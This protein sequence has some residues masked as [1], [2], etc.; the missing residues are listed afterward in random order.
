MSSQVLA[1]KFLIRRPEGKLVFKC[2]YKDFRPNQQ[3]PS[4]L[5]FLNQKFL[6][7]D[8]RSAKGAAAGKMFAAAEDFYIDEYQKN[9][10]N[11]AVFHS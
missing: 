4:E 8:A 3:K 9:N 11:K 1:I 6:K 10:L 7:R 2:D 5:T